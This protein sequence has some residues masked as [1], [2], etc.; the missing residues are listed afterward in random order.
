MNHTGNLS[1]PLHTWTERHFGLS[2]AV[3]RN[4]PDSGGRNR[5]GGGRRP[6]RCVQ[7]EGARRSGGTFGL[8]RR[9]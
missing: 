1:E 6:F 7:S 5:T 3:L 9:D 4:D 2:L 8:D